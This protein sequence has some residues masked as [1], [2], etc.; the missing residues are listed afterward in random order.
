MRHELH[1]SNTSEARKIRVRHECYTKDTSTT[2]VKN[3]FDFDNDK[4]KIIFSH[5]YIRYMVDEKL[6]VEEQ[7]LQNYKRHEAD[8]GHPKKLLRSS[9]SYS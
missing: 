6:Q 2:R 9:T 4:S 7:Y 3:Y 8:Q 1:E 5:H